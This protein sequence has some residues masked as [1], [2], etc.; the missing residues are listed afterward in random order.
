MGNTSRFINNEEAVQH[1]IEKS[2]HTRVDPACSW[3]CEKVWMGQMLGTYYKDVGGVYHITGRYKV[4]GVSFGSTGGAIKIIN[5]LTYQSQDI[6]HYPMRLLGS[7]V[8]VSVPPR[9]AFER[10]IRAT[11]DGSLSYGVCASLLVFDE[12]HEEKLAFW[13]VIKSLFPTTGAFDAAVNRLERKV[14]L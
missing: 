10:T 12:G 7:L 4:V 14:S 2:K 9:T 11:T 1:F 3:H 6:T 5:T 13:P 8:A